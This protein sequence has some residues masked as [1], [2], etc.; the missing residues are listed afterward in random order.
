MILKKY[1]FEKKQIN[2]EYSKK[3]VEE[4]I[5][6][7]QDGVNHLKDFIIFNPLLLGLSIFVPGSFGLSSF[8][9]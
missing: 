2:Y 3:I 4:N 1:N 6:N 7:I 9:S 8:C 5:G